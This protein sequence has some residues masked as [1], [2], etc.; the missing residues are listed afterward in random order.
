MCVCVDTVCSCCVSPY[1]GALG[2]AE[3]GRAVDGLA[4]HGAG[5]GAIEERGA[6]G[7]ACRGRGRGVFQLCISITVVNCDHSRT[8]RDQCDLEL[9]GR[10]QRNQAWRS[11]YASHS[12]WQPSC[13]HQGV[14]ARVSWLLDVSSKRGWE[15]PLRFCLVGGFRAV[16]PLMVSPRLAEDDCA[17]IQRQRTNP[18]PTIR[19]CPM[20]HSL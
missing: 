11:Y 5:E 20:R 12:S 13:R 15:C 16:R 3:G 19:L 8:S 4:A 14:P 17:L 18:P 10:A 2:A 7:G 9:S 6:A 1:A